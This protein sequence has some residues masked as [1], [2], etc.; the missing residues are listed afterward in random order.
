MRTIEKSRELHYK[1]LSEWFKGTGTH[2]SGDSGKNLIIDGIFDQSGTWDTAPNAYWFSEYAH[3]AGW[4]DDH[5]Y[6]PR[7]ML[8]LLSEVK[9]V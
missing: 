6:R 1:K 2:P 9:R 7:L 3:H 8:N 5:H 4:V